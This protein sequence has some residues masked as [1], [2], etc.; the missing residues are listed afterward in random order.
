MKTL[1]EMIICGAAIAAAAGAVTIAGCGSGD[2]ATGPGGAGSMLSGNASAPLDQVASLPV[3]HSLLAS[4]GA[5]VSTLWGTPAQAV[6]PG[7]NKPLAGAAVTI[8]SRLTHQRISG[9]ATTNSDGSFQIPLPPDSTGEGLAAAVTSASGQIQVM[10]PIP[11]SGA[12]SV[13]VDEVSTVGE[14]AAEQAEA[15]GASPADADADADQVEQDQ[16]TQENAHPTES[17]QEPD[18]HTHNPNHDRR[19]DVLAGHH[20]QGDLDGK[21]GMYLG[22][23][24][25]SPSVRQSVMAAVV[26]ARAGEILSGMPLPVFGHEWVNALATGPATY[27]DT[28]I[29]AALVAG[30]DSGATSADVDASVLT[31]NTVLGTNITDA[32]QIPAAYFILI[33]LQP[34]A[35]QIQTRA[36]MDAA[37]SSLVGK[38]V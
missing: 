6:A 32:T 35:M 26:Y 36:G 38:T 7:G 33:A 27:S 28:Q 31:L 17:T 10:A 21:L 23:S 37:V 4:L 3:S 15:A 1:T 19:P 16:Q 5:S 14:L 13:A 2:G 24:N 12:S 11:V 20:L 34:G 25:H 29:A 8:I 9:P 18:L 22:A 30:G